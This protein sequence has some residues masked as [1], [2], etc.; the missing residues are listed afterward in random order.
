MAGDPACHGPHQQLSRTGLCTL[1]CM[2][3]Y[4]GE[5]M[6]AMMKR[7][8]RARISLCYCCISLGVACHQGGIVV[9]CHGLG[10]CLQGSR[11]L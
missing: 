1:A 4:Q 6:K 10:R 11:L 3:I 5:K 9:G 7:V 2:V 8:E